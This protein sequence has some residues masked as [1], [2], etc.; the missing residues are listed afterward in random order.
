M[1]D[2]RLQIDKQKLENLRRY[3]ENGEGLVR[4]LSIHAYQQYSYDNVGS[5]WKELSKI[6]RKPVEQLT[7]DDFLCREMIEAVRLLAGDELVEDFPQ[8][9]NLCMAGQYSNSSFRRSYASGNIAFYTGRLERLV[10]RLIFQSC[11]QK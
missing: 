4:A 2:N 6:H 9:V 5:V 10:S 3:A 7:K 11:C 1:E 8:I